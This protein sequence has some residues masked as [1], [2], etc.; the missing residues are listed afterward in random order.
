MASPA[1]RKEAARLSALFEAAGAVPVEADLMQPAEVLL[2]LYGEDIRGRAYVTHDPVRGELML[3]PDFTVPVVQ[4]HM[5]DGAE[6]A[7]Y[8]YQG[9]VFRMQ[10]A[11][12]GRAC[13]YLQ[14]GYE[15]FEREDSAAA[16]AEVF[17]IFNQAL[18]P[19]DLRR[20]TGDIGVLKAAISGLSTSAHRRAAL[21]R[22]IWRP[23]RF[24]ALLDRFA[25]K[26]T[27]AKGRAETLAALS[28]TPAHALVEQYGEQPGLRGPKDV[29]ARLETLV[30]DARV[31]AI[32]LDE[33]EAIGALL[34]LS[35]MM[36][37]AVVALREIA[38]ALPAISPAIDGMSRR[39]DAL[40]RNDIDPGTL[41][42]E[43]S[44]GRTN[45]EYYDGFVFGFY[46]LD[47]AAPVA[48]GGRYDA[49]T[50]VLGQGREIPAV[51]G[52]I[53][54]EMTAEL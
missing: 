6:P 5:S 20:A 17:S 2:D 30:E 29:V 33:Y 3:R 50:K 19:Y 12:T 46:P 22:H 36:P 4:M 27:L 24:R 28:E 11:G 49:L 25:G 32:P 48:S 52:V 47:G 13:E 43:G 44:Y 26:G 35:Q 38:K 31:P 7:R 9:D 23:T 53:R 1:A 40:A 51:G 18:E 16:D 41:P 14:V 37:E 34:G 45:M 42:F 21:V 8:T 54:P 10:Q 39:M 15:L